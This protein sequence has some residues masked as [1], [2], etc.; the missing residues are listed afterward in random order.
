MARRWM[1]RSAG[2]VAAAALVTLGLPAGQVMASAAAGASQ[3]PESNPGKAYALPK[4]KTSDAKPGS[5]APAGET[6]MQQAEGAAVAEAARVHH[7]VAVAGLQTEQEIVTAAGNG[8]LTMR[9]YP[10]PVQVQR[11]GAWIP[12][13]TN[14]RAEDGALTAPVL[15]GDSVQF[16]AGGSGP[17][18]QIGT[19]QSG[20][21]LWWPVPLPT[22]VVS[23]PTATYRNALPGVNLVLTA[24]NGTTGAFNET[25]VVSSSQAAQNL[26][27]L[28]LRVS[29]QGTRLATAGSGGL[30]APLPGGSAFVASPAA[31]WDSGTSASGLASRA[32]ATGARSAAATGSGG[33]PISSAQ[34]PGRDALVAPVP[35]QVSGGGSQL[36]LVPD[37]KML[38]SALTVFPV[39]ISAATF[40]L[41]S[42]SP[43]AASAASAS[44]TGVRLTSFTTLAASPSLYTGTNGGGSLQ[45]YDPVQSTCTSSHYN[46]ASYYDSPVGYDNWGG[47]CAV[48]DTDYALYRVGVS[49]ALGASGVT[50]ATA[51]VNAS[52]A[53]SSSCSDSSVVSLTWIGVINSGTGWPGPAAHSGQKSVNATFA[54][55]D[56]GGKG[57]ASTWSCSGYAKANDGLLSAATFHVKPDITSLLGA[58]NFT[59][60]LSETQS[61]EVAGA[62]NADYYHVQFANGKH[63]SDGPYLQVQFFDS[64]A[65]VS[66]S[67]MQESTSAA[68]NPTYTCALTGS[69]AQSIVPTAAGGGVWVGATHTDPD[70]ESVLGGTIEYFLASDPSSYQTLTVTDSPANGAYPEA[71]AEIPYSWLSAQANGAQIGWITDSYTGTSTIGGYTYGPYDSPSYSSA[72]YF[73]DFWS[74]PLAPTVTPNFTQADP[75]AVGST[76]TFSITPSPGDPS[77][78]AEYV[79]SL[80]STPPMSGTIPAS[81]L[82]T[83]SAATTPYCVIN[84]SGDA[85]LSVEV[86]SPGPHQLTVYEIDSGNVSSGE[87]TAGLPPVSG[88][89]PEGLNPGGAWAGYTFTG[90]S[91]SGGAPYISGSSLQANFA[92][93][94]ASGTPPNTLISSSSGSAC[95]ASTGGDGSGDYLDAQ[96]LTAA[97]WTPGGQVTVDGA[98]F[99]LP[100]FG[101]CTSADNLLAANQTIGTGGG[102]QGS[103]VV[104]LATSTDGS[105]PGSEATVPGLAT[106]DENAPVLQGDAT[107]PAV[108]GTTAT[109]GSGCLQVPTFGDAGCTPANGVVTYAAGCPE[110]GGQ[111]TVGYD[112]TVPDWTTGPADL[113]AIATADKVNSRGAQADSPK[114]YAFA[115]PLDANCTVESVTLPDIGAAAYAATPSGDGVVLPALHIFGMSIRNTTTA[116]PEANGASV[117]SPSGQAWT[118]AA[119]SPVEDAF[120]P[121]SQVT[122]GNQTFREQV[123][124][125]VSGAAGS[126]VRIQLS[127][128][129]FLAADGTGPL[130][131]GAASIAPGS[132]ATPGQAPVPLTFG[133]HSSVT[134]PDGGAIYSDPVSLSSAFSVTAGSPLLVSLWIQNASLP[135]LPLN[136]YASAGATWWASSSTPNQTLN[137]SGTPFTGSTGGLIGATAVLTGVD[138]TTPAGTLDGLPSPGSPTV[139]V[140]GDNVID[141][142]G[143]AAF[144]DSLNMPSQR[145][146]G[147]LYSQGLAEGS[148]VVDAGIEGNQILADGS[149][150]YGVSLLARLDRDVLAE[151]DVGT[152]VIDEGLQDLL[153]SAPSA[154]SLDTAYS[155]LIEELN[156]YGIN[157]ILTTMT[158]CAGYASDAHSCTATATDPVRLQVNQAIAGSAII[159]NGPPYCLA[160][161]DS[162]VSNGASPEVLSTVPTNYD[163]GDHAN[164]SAAGYAALADVFNPDDSQY[165]GCALSPSSDTLPPP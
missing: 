88:D 93:A 100:S 50:V 129:G 106:G 108:M 33:L 42:G 24:E 89:S 41:A 72:C 60:R 158:P 6:A 90:A 74:K 161:A 111:T 84:G 70:G 128:P 35:E 104:F 9:S 101:T 11:S 159:D 8:M 103:S 122:W 116:T 130:Q 52:V 57:A 25:L 160:D 79:Y 53:Y 69:A 139:V 14:L 3:P 107:T 10:L 61:N 28:Q 131:I 32:A 82:C 109:T 94:L 97:G 146:A 119:E 56:N 75:Q 165:S 143:S 138:V 83:T 127:D 31:M 63:A 1:G 47:S 132:G 115:V 99:T 95:P 80:D 48:N 38:D 125:T 59:F 153:N 16:S 20:L 85:T 136:T 142:A 44:P 135:A 98:S 62:T 77:P 7:P 117:P 37:A 154:D 2:L 71:W 30:T 155:I 124:P 118:G 54:P 29:A 87:T 133:G 13:D 64:P 67:T 91:D 137:T 140:A 134:I 76:V 4:P 145:L 18:A 12:V 96:Q 149:G 40:S 112:L 68:F 66:T 49:T 58:S 120:A 102:V 22:P 65:T 152:V 73:N 15:P 144:S 114:I 55:D 43:A 39:D 46:S 51:T 126:Q 121:P 113:Q 36:R 151:P 148:G 21:T 78:P 162:A 156:A 17:M 164:L 45:A 163:A 110:T 157:V 26:S 105:S 147:Q 123:T 150:S 92:Q 34:G 86:S 81:E 5:F 27:A 19:G 141:G 23:G